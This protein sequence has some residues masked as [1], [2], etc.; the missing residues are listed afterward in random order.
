MHV[1][2]QNTPVSQAMGLVSKREKELDYLKNA[3]FR[4]WDRF[5]GGITETF[6]KVFPIKDSMVDSMIIHKWLL[7]WNGGM[8]VAV[9]KFKELIGKKFNI[10]EPLGGDVNLNYGSYDFNFEI[11]DI[12]QITKN[13]FNSSIFIDVKVFGDG[14]LSLI[15]NEPENQGPITITQ[16]MET[17]DAWEIKTEIKDLI[18]DWTLLSFEEKYG[19][20]I[21]INKIYYD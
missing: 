4:Y 8:D 16:A 14:T 20:K 21:H 15:F 13:E 7:E 9:S 10:R 18:E 6:S 17:E 2:K 3:I 12:D 5:E 19:I 11:I 1:E